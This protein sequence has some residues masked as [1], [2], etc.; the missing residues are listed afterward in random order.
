MPANRVA[1]A[2]FLRSRRDRLKPAQAGVQP[3]PGPRRV[4]GLRREE[5]AMLA[6]LSVDYYTRIEQG[7]Q[8]NISAEVLA[9]LSRAL[10]LD[11]IERA[12][13][14]D[15]AAPARSSDDGSPPQRADPGLL[16]VMRALGHLPVLLLGRRS[17]VL[18]RTPLLEAVL[19]HD[20]EIGDSFLHY[21][22]HDP[23]ARL[24][25]V[26]W[27][28]FARAAVAGMRREAGTH[29]HDRRLHAEITA[30]RR[31][32]PKVDRWWQDQQVGDYTSAAKQIVHPELGRLHFD[33]EHIIAPHDPDQHLIVYTT[34]PDSPTALLLPMLTAPEFTGSGLPA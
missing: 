18:A 24:R 21:L 27:E 19:G 30:L 13:L 26:N 22:F 15:L 9:A 23:L 8:A 4:P 6:G 28:V 33:I 32:N 16:R 11:D 12:H 7:R 5:L 17:A 1:L 29:P 3:F 25:I 31:S 34:P 2:E 10:Q 20:F 14:R